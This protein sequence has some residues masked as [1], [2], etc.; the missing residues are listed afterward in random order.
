MYF[1][2]HNKNTVY[3]NHYSGL[4]EVEGEGLTARAF[5]HELDHLDGTLFT[6]KASRMLTPEELQ[7]TGEA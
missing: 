6:T 2:K 3:I 5:C 1:S 4:L 7:G